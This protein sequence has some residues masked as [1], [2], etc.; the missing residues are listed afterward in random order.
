MHENWGFAMMREAWLAEQAARGPE[1]P[2]RRDIAD[3][4]LAFGQIEQHPRHSEE[5]SREN[6]IIFE[7]QAVGCLHAAENLLLGKLVVFGNAEIAIRGDDDPP[8]QDRAEQV[9]A[10]RDIVGICLRLLTVAVLR[11]VLEQHDV[12]VPPDLW[13]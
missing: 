4:R 12:I 1:I 10:G 13:P 9:D 8:R 7:K 11:P 2:V 6:E 5:I 3:A